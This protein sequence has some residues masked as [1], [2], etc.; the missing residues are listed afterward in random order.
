MQHESHD[1]I[2]DK[3]I[4]R[5]QNQM[6]KLYRVVKA[7]QLMHQDKWLTR[8]QIQQKIPHLMGELNTMGT[9][10]S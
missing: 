3:Q 7:G 9:I 6:I 5:T 4:K 1:Q 10:A 8:G 2:V